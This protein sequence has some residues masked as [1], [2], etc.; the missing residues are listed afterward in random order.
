MNTPEMYP[1]SFC[2]SLFAFVCTNRVGRCVC[3]EIFE[4][5]LHLTVDPNCQGSKNIFDS[6]FF[7]QMYLVPLMKYEWAFFLSRGGG[8]L[9]TPFIIVI[10]IITMLLLLL[11]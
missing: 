8:I 10:S 6:C 3:S 11:L 5:S 7:F 9:C 4:L 2:H 1:A